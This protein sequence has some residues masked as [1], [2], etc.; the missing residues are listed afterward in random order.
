MNAERWPLD[1]E[2][3]KRGDVVPVSHVERIAGVKRDDA[4]FAFH[5][6]KLAKDIEHYFETCGDVVCVK[7]VRGSLH[8]LTHSRQAEYVQQRARH[9]VHGYATSYRKALGVDRALLTDEAR[10]RLDRF[11]QTTAF[12]LQQM[13]KP[14]PPELQP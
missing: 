7:S 6:L 9:H 10:K 3:L 4:A 2:A 5:A 1:F 8:V 11:L 13:R 12:R 14:P